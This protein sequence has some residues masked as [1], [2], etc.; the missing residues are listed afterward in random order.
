MDN[1]HLVLDIKLLTLNI[2]NWIFGNEQSILDKLTMNILAWTMVNGQSNINIGQWT[3]DN[4][5]QTLNR[6]DNGQWTSN[7]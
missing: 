1:G 6:I 5:Q 3:I 2:G 7:I 4:G